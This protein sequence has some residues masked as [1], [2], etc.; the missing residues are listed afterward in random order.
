MLVYYILS[1]GRH[2]FGDDLNCQ[3]KISEGDYNLEHLKDVEAKDLVESM[4][5]DDQVKRPRITEVL[6]HPYF[7]EEERYCLYSRVCGCTSAK[8]LFILLTNQ[9]TF[10]GVP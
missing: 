10:Y 3:A 1:G 8:T 7:W 5:N 4:I 6:K 9:Q 2:P